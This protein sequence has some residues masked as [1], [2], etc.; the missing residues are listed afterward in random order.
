MVKDRFGVIL[1]HCTS[2]NFP[3]FSIISNEFPRNFHFPRFLKLRY[4]QKI[5]K[6]VKI[7]KQWIFELQKSIIY[8]W[9]GLE[10][11]YSTITFSKTST[12]TI[13]SKKPKNLETIPSNL[14]CQWKVFNNDDKL[15]IVEKVLKNA[16]Q[17]WYFRKL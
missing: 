11:C 15:Y 13:P 5:L 10:K 14:V 7:R 6:H 8:R 4:L 9:K 12:E 3:Y 17:C 16:I 2:V 1:K